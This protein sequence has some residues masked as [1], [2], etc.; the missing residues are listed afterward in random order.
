[1]FQ[2]QRP[3]TGALQATTDTVA[4]C[5]G[6]RTCGLFT[7]VEWAPPVLVRIP[8]LIGRDGVIARHRSKADSAAHDSIRTDDILAMGARGGSS[9]EL[10]A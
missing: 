5:H 8:V 3:L 10:A 2:T 1:M 9:E 7:E 6:N 4:A